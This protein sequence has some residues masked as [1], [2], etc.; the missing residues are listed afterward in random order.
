M[1]GDERYWFKAKRYGWGWG[2]PSTWQGWLVLGGYLLIN[3]VAVLLL[4]E[5]DVIYVLLP[6][7]AALVV[8]CAAK[9]E[10]AR[11]RWGKR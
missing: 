1:V 2:L 9:G 7:T 5:E 8:V 6:A 3:G 4:E 11:W 10:P